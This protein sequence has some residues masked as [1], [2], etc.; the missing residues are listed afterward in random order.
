MVLHPHRLP[1]GRAAQR[2]R[3]LETTPPVLA[4]KRRPWREFAVETH[5]K[6]T[7]ESGELVP[8]TSLRDGEAECM[9]MSEAFAEQRRG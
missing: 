3:G 1:H 7:R 6:D 2:H 5:C 9:D 8:W 4:V